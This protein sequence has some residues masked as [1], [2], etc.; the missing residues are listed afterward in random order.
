[1]RVAADAIGRR[2]VARPTRGNPRFHF[3]KPAAPRGELRI[4]DAVGGGALAGRATLKKARQPLH[5]DSR[6][7][8]R[9]GH[10][11]SLGRR[12]RRKRVVHFRPPKKQKDES[13]D[14]VPMCSH[15]VA[16][17]IMNVT[18]SRKK[19]AR[20]PSVMKGFSNEG[21]SIAP[22]ECAVRSSLP[23]V[24]RL[25]LEWRRPD[26]WQRMIASWFARADSLESSD[27][28][29]DLALHLGASV[30]GFAATLQRGAKSVLA[31]RRNQ[32][33]T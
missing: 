2:G 23:G 15:S 6:L 21:R 25:S 13:T 29:A 30:S 8:A 31:D 14:S 33:P 19:M 4:I 9:G 11:I 28:P 32:A 1:M 27:G 17:Q 3:P 20:K 5:P 7:L 26:G 22:G 18:G 16:R 12:G 24:A 10:G